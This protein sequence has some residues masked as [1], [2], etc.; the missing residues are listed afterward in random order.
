MITIGVCSHAFSGWPLERAAR[1]LADAGITHV[2][3]GFNN[4]R[5]QIDPVG[6]V[7]EPERV[8]DEVLAITQPLGQTLVELFMCPLYLPDGG[9]GSGGG[10][11]PNDP[12][13]GRREAMVRAFERVCV[14]AARAGFRNIM[15]VPG[16]IFGDEHRDEAIARAVPTLKRM[17][18]VADAAG[19]RFTIEP[20]RWSFLRS[21]EQ[22]AEFV[23]MIPGLTLSLDYSH[24]IG[25]GFPMGEIIGLH[26]VTEHAHAKP[27]GPG[28]F[29]ALVH[30]DA[31]DHALAIHDLMKRG[32]DGVVSTECI[33][34]DGQPTLTES[35]AFQNILLAHELEM[36]MKGAIS[37]VSYV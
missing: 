19:T 1:F 26:D 2:S 24:Y 25:F 32:W 6:A 8:A 18:E 4:P 28:Y 3:P 30:E 16:S 37:K 21:P 13:S 31:S 15:G 27:S 10:V 34:P 14:F 35:A 29:K 12:D 5:A 23:A 22:V 11:E 33:Y 17:V 9:D 36:M 20:H 7:A